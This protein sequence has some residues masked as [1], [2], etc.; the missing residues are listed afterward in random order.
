MRVLLI[1]HFRNDCQ[2]SRILSLAREL[3]RRG[4]PAAAALIDMPP[5]IYREYS[6]YYSRDVRIFT[7]Q[8]FTEIIRLTRT[9]RISL[10]HLHCPTLLPLGIKLSELSGLPFG[11]T[12]KG[13]PAKRLLPLLEGASFVIA[14]D[15]RSF[16]NLKPLHPQ[17]IFLQEG[18]DLQEFLP[19]PHRENFTLTFVGE[20]GAY[21]TEGYFALLKAAT[22]A[23]LPLQI[24]CLQTPPIDAGQF[25]GWPPGRAHI[26]AK[27]QVVIG[28][29]RALLE[30]MACGNAA[31]ILGLNYLGI[32]DPAA[33][34]PPSEADLSGIGNDDDEPCYRTIFYDLS[35]LLKDSP[36]LNRLQEKGRQ[37]V[38]EN[39]DLR[40]I[41]E[42]A[43]G[44]YT[45]VD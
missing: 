10:I 45:Q 44:I 28:S 43:V 21:N 36:Y 32:L 12:I 9:L 19:A 17:T 27:S 15:A 1:D 39:Y 16:A 41:A 3:N 5:Q 38:R 35:R 20:Q 18:L 13:T 26:L 8:N 2:P 23:D 33:L 40:L 11:I 31:L 24:I 6:R 4:I 37:Q 30:G 7:P 34:P 25:R 29:G 22:I 14:S 42:Q